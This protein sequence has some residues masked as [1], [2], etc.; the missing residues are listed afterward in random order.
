M[1]R[2]LLIICGV[3]CHAE[4]LD[5]ESLGQLAVKVKRLLVELNCGSRA[6][7]PSEKSATLSTCGGSDSGALDD[8]RLDSHLGEI[9]SRRGSMNTASNYDHFAH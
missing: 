5:L 6:P 8:G 7:F 1:R 9:V 4:R 3:S 2:K